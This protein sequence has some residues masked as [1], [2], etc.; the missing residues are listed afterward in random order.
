MPR[1]LSPGAWLAPIPLSRP[2]SPKIQ[3]HAIASFHSGVPRNRSGGSSLRRAS[4]MA[5]IA[6]VTSTQDKGD[7]RPALGQELPGVS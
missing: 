1:G 5:A 4:S 3:P 2:D 6:G 7:G